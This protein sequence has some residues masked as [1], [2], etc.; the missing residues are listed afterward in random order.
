MKTGRFAVCTIAAGL[1]VLA[2]LGTA[3]RPLSASNLFLCQGCSNPPSAPTLLTNVNTITVGVGGS[4]TLQNPLLIVVGVLNG[5]GTPSISYSGCAVPS[6]CPLATVGTYGLTANTGTFKSSSGG[7]AF[8]QLGLSAGSSQNWTNWS[9]LDSTDGFGTASSYSLYAFELP[10]S[11]ASDSPITIDESGAALGSYIIGYSCKNGTGSSAGCASNGDRADT[12][13]TTS[14][15]VD[16][17]AAQPSSAML[18][19]V[20]LLGFVGLALFERRRRLA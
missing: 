6:A 13:F 2:L 8:S 7:T 10:V 17:T 4:E 11:V 5:N 1:L 20:V 3:P 12:P 9:G 14:G 18:V 19:G 15:V 16:A